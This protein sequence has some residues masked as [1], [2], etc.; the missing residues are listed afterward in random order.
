MKSRLTACLVAVAA[1]LVMAPAF[2]AVAQASI[3]SLVRSSGS[4]PILPHG[5]RAV[6]ALPGDT[7]ISVDVVLRPRDTAAVDAFAQAVSTPGTPV[8]RQYLAPGEFT[9]MFGPTPSTVS[10]VRSW[11]SSQ[12]LSVGSTA[13]DGFVVPVKGAAA[14]IAK[15]FGIGFESYELTSGRVVRM[16]T[17]EP[18][19]PSDLAGALIGVIGLDDLARPVPELVHGLNSRATRLGAGSSSR[20]V[21]G[22]T[23]PRAQ[24]SSG[25]QADCSAMTGAGLSAT[26]VEVVRSQAPRVPSTTRGRI[27]STSTSGLR[28]GTWSS[29]SRT[30]LSGKCW[31]AYDL[32][33]DSGG[34]GVE[35]TPSPV[36]TGGAIQ[37][38]VGGS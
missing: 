25:P 7:M 16:P 33:G 5:S 32:T 36:V 38:Y 21:T 2:P 28:A 29:T 9:A 26:Q 20:P 3:M 37:V 19:V 10:A 30:T 8:F 24:T 35:G 13:Q 14:M 15:A 11:L 31:N 12:G 34:P 22:A 23:S 18:L 6:G 27:S 1:L 4:V 17:A